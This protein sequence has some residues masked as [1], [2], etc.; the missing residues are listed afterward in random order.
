AVAP[1]CPL[2]TVSM[3][4]EGSMDH[5]SAA[6][7][8]RLTHRPHHRCILDDRF[9]DRFEEHLRHMVHLTDGQ[10]LSQCIVMPTL[11]VYRELGIRVLLRGHAGELMHMTK[12]YNFSL[13][14]QALALRDESELEAWLF[15]RLQAY[16]LDG[17]EGRLFAPAL[18]GQME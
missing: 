13:D 4:V 17:T 16:M 11:P 5:E 6:E 3:G 8:A 7:L 10:Y 2:T 1:D 14:P 18:R 15:G 12:A 9:L